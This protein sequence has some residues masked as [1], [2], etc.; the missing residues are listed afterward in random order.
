MGAELLHAD[1]GQTDG[2]HGS[3]SRSL[4]L[5]EKHAIITHNFTDSS[6][7]TYAENV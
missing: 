4:Q 5:R 3:S 6:L 1:I 2:R 7:F